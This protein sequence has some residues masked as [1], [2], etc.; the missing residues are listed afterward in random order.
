[1]TGGGRAPSQATAQMPR[2]SLTKV[3]GSGGADCI[4]H[5]EV[6]DTASAMGAGAAALD[7]W[8][9]TQVLSTT[10]ETFG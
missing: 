6:R 5:M 7:S 4:L 1:M 2:E 3:A 9:K 10:L 8:G